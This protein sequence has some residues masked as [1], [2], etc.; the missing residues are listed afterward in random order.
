MRDRKIQFVRHHCL[1]FSLHGLLLVM[2]FKFGS[3]FDKKNQNFGQKTTFR[4]KIEVQE[5]V[6]FLV[7]I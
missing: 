6:P 2:K 1:I 4:L 5:K 7:R 3:K